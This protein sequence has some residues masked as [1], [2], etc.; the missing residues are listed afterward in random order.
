MTPT[1]RRFPMKQKIGQQLL[2]IIF[3]IIFLFHV[4]A[5]TAEYV[6]N[7]DATVTDLSTGLVWEK[8]GSS[9]NMTWEAALAWCLGRNTAGRSDWRLPDI[10][11][12]ESLLDDSRYSPSIAPVF[13]A[14]STYYWSSTP[15]S[16]AVWAVD[17]WSGYTDVHNQYDTLRSRCVSGGQGAFTTINFGVPAILLL[18]F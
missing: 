13:T 11:E 14:S 16:W 9:E 3:V 2:I 12:L 6:D 18:L 8:T 7:G 10:R 17:F 5:A 4:N 15:K 1:C